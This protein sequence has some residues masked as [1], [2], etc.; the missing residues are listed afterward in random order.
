MEIDFIGLKYF[1]LHMSNW[2]RYQNHS[3]SLPRTI[4]GNPSSTLFT[5]SG[6]F[7]NKFGELHLS[8]RWLLNCYISMTS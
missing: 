4:T 8:K 2:S 3:L 6:L 7:D 1:W 5:S